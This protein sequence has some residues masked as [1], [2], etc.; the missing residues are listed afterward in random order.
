M[1]SQRL[2]L[3]FIVKCHRTS[4]QIVRGPVCKNVSYECDRRFGGRNHRTSRNTSCC[5]AGPLRAR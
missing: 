3:A 5:L 1:D 2:K 4:V